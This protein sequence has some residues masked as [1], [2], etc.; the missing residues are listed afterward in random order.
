MCLLMKLQVDHQHW[1][2]QLQWQKTK[3]KS[4]LASGNCYFKGNYPGRNDD[5]NSNLSA[6]LETIELCPWKSECSKSLP[7][8]VKTVVCL[9]LIRELYSLLSRQ[10]Q[11]VSTI[12]KG[13]KVLRQ[14]SHTWAMHLL[15]EGIK[16]IPAL[17]HWLKL[18]SA[19]LP[20]NFI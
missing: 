13:C 6:D 4:L 15:I 1:E 14:L 10:W 11:A 2:K 7:Q 19:T 18:F 3:T 16:M 5:R 20:P 8:V 12:L 9:W 17:H